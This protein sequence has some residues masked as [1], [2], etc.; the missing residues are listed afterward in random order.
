ME[1]T[2]TNTSLAFEGQVWKY[3]DG[4]TDCYVIGYMSISAL[5]QF[6]LINVKTLEVIGFYADAN[7]CVKYGPMV[8]V[9]DSLGEY[10]DMVRRTPTPSKKKR[11]NQ[12]RDY[13]CSDR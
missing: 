13:Q 11:Q 12:T 6:V 10:Y 9:S 7:E 2:G 8:K 4:S 3:D 1:Q 5:D